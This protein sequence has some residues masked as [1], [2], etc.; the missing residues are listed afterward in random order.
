MRAAAAVHSRKG[1]RSR[2][3]A[4][5]AAGEQGSRGRHV[6]CRSSAP[7]GV[8]LVVLA[9]MER[10]AVYVLHVQQAHSVHFDCLT[11]YQLGWQILSMEAERGT[12]QMA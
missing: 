8:S 10:K 4:D 2:E 11:K 9:N 6:Q 1:R 12:S 3:E 5:V 7:T